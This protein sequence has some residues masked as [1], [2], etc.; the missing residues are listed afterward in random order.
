M[1]H[2]DRFRGP[3]ERTAEGPEVAQELLSTHHVLELRNVR[4]CQ[5]LVCLVLEIRLL[6]P[7]VIVLN[8]Q[9]RA[10]ASGPVS[11]GACGRPQP[12]T[13]SVC[14]FDNQLKSLL[15]QE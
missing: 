1:A 8:V 5:Q 7:I 4:A 10:Y 6:S 13:P 14:S 3:R 2:S 11:L 15:E 9:R 12:L